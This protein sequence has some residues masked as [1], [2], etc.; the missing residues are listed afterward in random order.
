MLALPFVEAAAA[1]DLP[2]RKGAL[3]AIVELSAEGK[4]AELGESKGGFRLSRM[5]SCG[6]GLT[7]RLEPAERPK[8]WRF[9]SIPL[10][11]QG[12]RVQALLRACS[13]CRADDIRGYGTVVAAS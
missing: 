11:A 1:V 3:G 10:N 6:A 9:A 5:R 4:S 12:K 13:I 7:E 8:H 2:D